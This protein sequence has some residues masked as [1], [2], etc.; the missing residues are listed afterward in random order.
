M[1]GQGSS[2]RAAVNGVVR[3][4]RNRWGIPHVSAD[5]D[6]DLF[7]GFGY[8]M[9][10]DRL[11]Q[12]DYLRR[13][14]VGR[15]SEILGPDGLEPDIVART[16]DLR[17]IAEA[18]WRQTPDE[19]RRLVTAFSHGV[20]AVIA[21][22]GDRLPI[23]FDLLDYAPEPWSPVDCLA[24]AGE[25]RAY[26]TVRLPVIFIPE[27]GKRTLGEG[28]LYRAFL[29]GEADDESILPPGSYPAA[30]V[31]TQPVGAAVGDPE[32]GVGSNNWVIAGSRST[33]GKPMVASDPHIAFAAVSCWYEVT[34]AG[35]SFNVTGMAYAGMPAVM[36]GRNVRV[37]WGI[38]N[39]ICSQRDLYQERTDPGAP[40]RLPLRRPV[41]AGPGAGRGDQGA[42]RRN[43]PEDHPLVAQR[44]HRG[45]TTP[46]T[47]ACE[48]PG[49]AALAG[50]NLLRLAHVAAGDGSRQNGR[51]A[52]G[53]RPGL[54][55]ADVESGAGRRGGRHWVPGCRP[56]S[57]PQRG[58]T[59]LPPRLGPGA[60][61]GGLDSVGEYAAVE[62]SGAR[63]DRFGEQPDRSR[64]LSLSSVRSLGE[65]LPRPPRAAA[66]RSASQALPRRLRADA[67]RRA[68]VTRRGRHAGTVAG[69]CREL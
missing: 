48:R 50:H 18:E 20:N 11:F 5:T 54:A 57:R 42:G 30:P 4:D 26:L 49:V 25:F 60:P 58:G 44:S 40:R 51:R 36:F 61:V 15:L 52:A 63:V 38:T 37:A 28:A 55:R 64:R 46:G 27:L 9:A 22:S 53:G 14:A 62:R 16:L 1:P 12:L 56:D 24:I 10:Q 13:K 17:R 3:I 29:E 67:P 6:E 68:L 31:G 39:N 45:R 32:E 23:E 35:G 2:P 33:T 47:G 21:A 8:A 7:F 34:L 69:A 65:R 66:A 41:G 59:G 43:D 19:T